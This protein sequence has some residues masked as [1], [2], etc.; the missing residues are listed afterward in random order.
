M[1]FVQKTF[2]YQFI[3][4]LIALLVLTLL[5]FYAISPPPPALLQISKIFFQPLVNKQNN[6]Q[7]FKENINQFSFSFKFFMARFQLH[8]NIT[9][10]LLPLG[11]L[12]PYPIFYGQVPTVPK[13]PCK[14]ITS[15]RT[16][17]LSSAPWLGPNCSKASL[18]KPILI[19]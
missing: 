2:P 6:M 4:F 17:P 1:S 8:K 13:H 18:W 14:I 9:V 19:S 10:K 12:C 15:G 5:S 16:L 11:E 3:L 7:V